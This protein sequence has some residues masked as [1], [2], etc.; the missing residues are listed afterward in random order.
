M[1]ERSEEPCEEEYFGDNK[2]DYSVTQAF[3]YNGCVM[4]L[5]GAF[6]DYVASSLVHGE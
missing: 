1:V 6:S 2:Q 5:V 4:S 3:L